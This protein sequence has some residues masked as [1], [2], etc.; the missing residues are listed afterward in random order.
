VDRRSSFR[1]VVFWKLAN[2]FGAGSTG[3]ADQR[4]DR[5]EPEERD[6]WAKNDLSLPPINVWACP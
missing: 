5:E 1:A 6:D 2:F 3:P 4:E